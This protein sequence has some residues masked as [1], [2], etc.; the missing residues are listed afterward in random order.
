MCLCGVTGCSD[1]YTLNSS[2]YS[3]TKHWQCPVSTD[4]TRPVVIS[5]LWN[6]IGVDRTL[7]LS[8]RPLTS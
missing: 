2:V 4:R 6:L 7:A 5:P 8:V 3:V 1:Q